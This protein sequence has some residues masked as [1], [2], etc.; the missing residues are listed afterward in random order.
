[1]IKQRF[2]I[3][4]YL[5]FLKIN[6][7]RFEIEKRNV[8]N[9][10]YRIKVYDKDFNIFYSFDFYSVDLKKDF[11]ELYYIKENFGLDFEIIE[12]IIKNKKEFGINN[13]KIP[14]T[15][16]FI[17]LIC[18]INNIHYNFT[19]E[20]FFYKLIFINKLNNEA[21]ISI[22]YHKKIH[23]IDECLSVDLVIF[24]EEKINNMFIKLKKYFNIKDFCFNEKSKFKI[25]A[26]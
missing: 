22:Q 23:N 2:H 10:D 3:A 6:N 21:L 25:L 19:E 15:L 17:I 12:K 13:F 8:S 1:M 26:L 9:Y 18:Y 24:N 16:S 7:I 11:N 20:D 4:E 5:E 14:A